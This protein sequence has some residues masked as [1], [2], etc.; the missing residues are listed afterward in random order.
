MG[1][2]REV[3]RPFLLSSL[4]VGGGLC[5]PVRGTARGLGPLVLG[6]GLR[7]GARGGVVIR[8]VV[9]SP[10]IVSGFFASLRVGGIGART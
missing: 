3:G 2:K 1:G 10:L 5:V 7:L 4:G 6:V 9:S 8:R